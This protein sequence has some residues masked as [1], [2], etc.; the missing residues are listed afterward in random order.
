MVTRGV[1]PNP[2]Q[3]EISTLDDETYLTG[4]MSWPHGPVCAKHATLAGGARAASISE[5]PVS[6]YC[7]ETVLTCRSRDHKCTHCKTGYSGSWHARRFNITSLDECARMCTGCQNCAFVSYLPS[8]QPASCEWF[9]ECEAPLYPM[10]GALSR[11]VPRRQ[12]DE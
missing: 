5:T 10:A 1:N 3:V 11:A 8:A 2:N 7:S 12:Q 6:G 9:S 4:H